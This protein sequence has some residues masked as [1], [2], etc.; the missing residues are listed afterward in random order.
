MASNVVLALLGHKWRDVFGLSRLARPRSSMG[1]W[2]VLRSD[3]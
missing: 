3:A 1:H 2:V